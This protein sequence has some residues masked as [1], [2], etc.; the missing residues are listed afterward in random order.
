[1][2]ASGRDPSA[3]SPPS[4]RLAAADARRRHSRGATS[5]TPGNI[6]DTPLPERTASSVHNGGSHGGYG[7]GFGTA[8]AAHDT[9]QPPCIHPHPHRIAACG[10][11][12]LVRPTSGYRRQS[13]HRHGRRGVPTPLPYGARWQ[14]VPAGWGPATK[15]ISL[16]HMSG[17]DK[18]CRLGGEVHYLF[19]MLTVGV[20]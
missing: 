13:D 5:P 14:L 16:P 18:A 15:A 2:A 8:T 9:R 4:G 17:S 7:V 19:A 3:R 10:M 12:P 11:P 1:P 6:S 20:P